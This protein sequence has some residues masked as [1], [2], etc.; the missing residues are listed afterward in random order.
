MRQPTVKV[1]LYKRHQVCRLDG[2]RRNLPGGSGPVGYVVWVERRRM[3]WR[4]EE[5]E[6]RL[7]GTAEPP[8]DE[9]RGL[10]ARN[11]SRA[12]LQAARG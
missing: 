3:R 4:S 6:V 7:T 12:K 2:S 1:G 10:E 8:S 11:E 5:E 9:V